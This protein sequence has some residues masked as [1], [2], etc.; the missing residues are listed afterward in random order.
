MRT[1]AVKRT[2]KS[3]LCGIAFLLAANSLG[4][5]QEDAL[6]ALRRVEGGLKSG[7]V[8]TAL[9]TSETK[10]YWEVERCFLLG[11]DLRV[12]RIVNYHP[13]QLLRNPTILI[14]IRSKKQQIS[15]SIAL[16]GE[17]AD[18]TA[19]FQRLDSKPSPEIRALEG[20]M[21][22]TSPTLEALGWFGSGWLSEKLA[23]AGDGSIVRNGDGAELTWGKRLIFKTRV[24]LVGDA[25]LLDGI[26][27]IP[28]ADNHFFKTWRI[29][30]KKPNDDAIRSYEKTSLT[31]D[32][33]DQYRVDILSLEHPR[34]SDEVFALGFPEHSLI[35]SV[36]DPNSVDQ[37]VNGKRVKNYRKPRP[38]S[39]RSM[40]LPIAG[41]TLGTVGFFLSMVW[42][43]RR[44]AGIN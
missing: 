39:T 33:I 30:P 16:R 38:D 12:D 19:I 1:S 6:Q 20:H 29:E 5:Q 31:E 11:E 41:L 37:I 10:P 42:M 44:R 3:I 22:I 4:S 14:S 35:N 23:Q 8:L 2:R 9:M 24:R 28:R 36:D 21:T 40:V 7:T 27:Y 32:H 13:G 17:F 43:K 26:E 15:A 18:A 34:I 25:A